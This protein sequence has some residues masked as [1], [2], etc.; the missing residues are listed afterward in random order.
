MK[1]QK[2]IR[3]LNTFGALASLFTTASCTMT[4]EGGTPNTSYTLI[5]P[6][7]PYE[8]D[9][10]PA[11]KHNEYFLLGGYGYGYAGRVYYNNVGMPSMPSMPTMGV[12]NG[13]NTHTYNGGSYNSH[14]ISVN[15]YNSSSSGTNAISNRP[16]AGTE[17]GNTLDG[18]TQY[19]KW[20]GPGPSWFQTAQPSIDDILMNEVKHNATG[21]TYSIK[22]KV[23]KQYQT[24]PEGTIIIDK[25]RKF[26]VY[27]FEPKTR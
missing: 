21:A 9:N 19:E 25:S 4:I 27:K 18:T 15:Y 1:K 20:Y 23:K 24:T 8:G 26:P 2:T 12:V 3:L 16:T 5:E 11:V 14:G 13:G 10:I 22:D 6:Q 7:K 17:L